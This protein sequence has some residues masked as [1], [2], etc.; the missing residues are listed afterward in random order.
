[1]NKK[2]SAIVESAMVFPM[3]VLSLVGL[4]YL[5][6]YFYGQLEMRVEMHET[7]RAE[8]GEICDNFKSYQY[9]DSSDVVYRKAQQI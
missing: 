5:M 4:I 9:D 2:G 7:L 6:I 1:M 3:V 8:S